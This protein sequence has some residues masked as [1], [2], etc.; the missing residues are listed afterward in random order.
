MI[1][2]VKFFLCKCL[3]A[4]KLY[5]NELLESLEVI[6]TQFKLIGNEKAPIKKYSD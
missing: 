1:E 5:P 2:N 4:Q 3:K 6:S